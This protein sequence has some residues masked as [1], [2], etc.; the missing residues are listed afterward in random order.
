MKKSLIALAVVAALVP[1]LAMAEAGDIVVRLR[2]THVNPSESSDLGQKTD[3]AYGA[4]TANLLYG[5]ANANL[6]VDSNTIPELDISY[7][8]TKN[9][10][11][12]LILATGTKHDV[13][14]SSAGAGLTSRKLGDVNLLPPTLTLQWHFNPDQM[15]DPYVGAGV[16]YVRALENGLTADTIGGGRPIRIDKNNWGVALQA[17]LDVNLE[18]RWLLNFDVKKIFVD[19]DVKLNTWGLAGT[20]TG[21]HKIDNLDIDPWVISVGFGKKF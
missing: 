5:N 17:G 7:Y 1:S 14:T 2:A 6:Q 16:S 4:G 9:I 19:T 8:I 3:K 18:N 21:Y 11:A 15:L 10:A 13:Q 12:E 20:A